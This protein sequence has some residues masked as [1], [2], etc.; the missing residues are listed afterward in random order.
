LAELRKLIKEQ[1]ETVTFSFVDAP[2]RVEISQVGRH[3]L[4]LEAIQHDSLGDRVLGAHV[5]R[6]DRFVRS[7]CFT[8]QRV[9]AHCKEQRWTQDLAELE[10]GLSLVQSCVEEPRSKSRPP[11]R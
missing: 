7:M 5:V 11:P 1:S 3:S 6:K 2:C 10:R 9:V 8:A 4:R